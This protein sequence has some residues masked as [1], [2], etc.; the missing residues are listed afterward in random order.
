MKK[1]MKAVAFIFISA[2]I[3]ALTYLALEFIEQG[4]TVEEFKV[5]VKETVIPSVVGVIAS[6]L[7][8]YFGCTPVLKNMTGASNGLLAAKELIGSVSKSSSDTSVS[9]DA[10]CKQL[11]GQIEEVKLLKTQ[12]EAQGKSQTETMTELLR[13]FVVLQQMIATGF[14]A[15]PE[16]VKSG[17]ARAIYKM[18]EEGESNEAE[19]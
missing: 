1:L 14:G 5:Y 16:L 17:N 6:L 11:V 10:V 12:M 18:M 15:M 9:V 19:S 3:G 13:Q 2:A 7:A 4:G 8:L